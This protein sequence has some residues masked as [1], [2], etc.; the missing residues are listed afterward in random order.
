MPRSSPSMPCSS[1]RSARSASTRA[2]C[3]GSRRR[4]S[5]TTEATTSRTWS[6]RN[7]WRRH[8]P[9]IGSQ[10]PFGR[11]SSAGPTGRR[12]DPRLIRCA[13]STTPTTESG[14]RQAATSHPTRPIP[15]SSTTN[16]CRRGRS[17]SGYGR[18]RASAGVRRTK[19]P[20]RSGR[21][22]QAGFVYW[23]TNSAHRSMRPRRF[24]NR[25]DRA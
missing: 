10:R 14:G 5:T 15:S 6:A 1:W 8:P 16:R 23:V 2:T 25:S 4:S 7:P 13:A 12:E 21:A 18:K 3:A 22:R 11:R 24:S 17:G 19:G 9:P 20:R